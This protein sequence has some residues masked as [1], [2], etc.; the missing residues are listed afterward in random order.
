V[1][2]VIKSETKIR[3]AYG[4]TLVLCEKVLCGVQCLV[5]NKLERIWKEAIVD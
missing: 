3:V 5:D 1:N 2:G 4:G